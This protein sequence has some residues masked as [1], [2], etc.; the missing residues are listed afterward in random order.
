M[1]QESET[2][3]ERRHQ[4]RGWFRLKLAVGITSIIVLMTVLF[5]CAYVILTP[6][7]FPPGVYWVSVVGLLG[8]LLGISTLAWKVILAPDSGH[9]LG[10]TTN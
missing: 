8:D 3:E 2:F 4:S 10:P 7:K 5:L 6:S 1:R 9:T